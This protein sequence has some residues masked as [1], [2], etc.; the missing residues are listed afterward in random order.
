MIPHTLKSLIAGGTNATSISSQ[1]ACGKSSIRR[2][3]I[4]KRSR[5]TKVGMLSSFH[6]VENSTIQLHLPGDF[7]VSYVDGEYVHG[8]EVS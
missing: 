3:T 5:E 1:P 6:E 2:K 7:L 4:R 8:L